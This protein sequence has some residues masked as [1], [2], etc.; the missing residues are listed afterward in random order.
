MRQKTQA[1]QRTGEAFQPCHLTVSQAGKSAVK[2]SSQECKVIFNAF[3]SLFL[4]L[5]IQNGDCFFAV[6]WLAVG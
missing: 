5:T 2:R 3:L 1:M 4:G 6:S